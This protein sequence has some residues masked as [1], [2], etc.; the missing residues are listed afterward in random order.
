[1]FTDAMKESKQSEISVSG[2]SA[3]GIE[4]MLNYAYTSK[5]ELNSANI[6]DVLSAAS[7]VILIPFMLS[8]DLN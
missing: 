8:P 4:L 3:R 2:I 7:Y 5:I 1:M 6:L